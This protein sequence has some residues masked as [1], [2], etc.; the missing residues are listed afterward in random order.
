MYQIGR[1]IRYLSR[2]LAFVALGLVFAAAA[3]AAA[4][5]FIAD[6]ETIRADFAR[7][8]SAW[9]GGPVVIS[10]PIRI[11]SF[12][13]LSVEA[14]GV[15]LQATP[16]LEPLSRVEAKSI[17]A[18]M[19]IASLFRGHLEFK[20]FVVVSPRFVFRRDLAEPQPSPYGLGT[21]GMA[22]AL[23]SRSPFADIEFVEPVFFIAGSGKSA[24]LRVELERLRVGRALPA[25]SSESS[26]ALG[27]PER[28]S[29]PFSLQVKS[30]GFEA[31]F[32][33]ECDND[34]ETATGAIRLNAA[35]DSPIAKTMLASIAPWER[36]E[37]IAVSGDL[38]WSKGR[39]ALDNATLSF[40]DHNAKG[41]LAIDASGRRA[42]LEGTIAYDTLDLTPAL[43]KECGEAD[44]GLEPRLLASLP[45]A[46]QAD[47]RSL[48]VD[49]RI[50]ADRF[51]AGALETGPLA[52]ALTAGKDRFA[53]DVAEMTLFGGNA[54][55]RLDITSA[56][57][58]W[59]SMRGTGSGLD[60]R[61][62]A[63]AFQLPSNV[64]GPVTV[65]AGLTMPLTS[66]PSVL[67]LAR[68]AGTFSIQFP[69]GG[70]LEGDMPQLLNAALAHQEIDWGLGEGSFPFAAASVDGTIRPGEV[71]FK[72]QGESGDKSIG[73][74][75][76]IALPGGTVSGTLSAS[77][78]PTVSGSSF[79]DSAPAQPANSM[80]LVLSGTA[81]QPVFSPL[82]KPSLSN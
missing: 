4:L 74:R 22:L 82:A 46:S 49:M 2:W 55:G 34:C 44:G 79:F 20:K 1:K 8:L 12:A 59:V 50:S 61:A 48:D 28:A 76:R 56:Q 73:G 17:T 16:G 38:N 77:Q 26:L 42:L 54:A 53:V 47:G 78:T 66:K 68:A 7:S 75:L 36:D 37:I 24:Y 18:I 5:P 23:S 32:R 31:V 40:G 29:S 52:L 39:A 63:N 33:G 45:F 19:R 60:P 70:S 27:V 11:A 65:H 58:G 15:H 69:S 3:F 71:D 64:T 21:A 43:I 30:R 35:L 51:R 72:V 25:S 81:A 80:Q 62:F 57:P 41:S 67:D 10:G 13:D 9:S 6:A 14:S